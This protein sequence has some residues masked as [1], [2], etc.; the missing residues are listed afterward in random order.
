M[1]ITEHFDSDE[2]SCHDGTDYPKEWI[3]SKLKPLCGDLE[4]IRALTNQQMNIES[5]Y[6]TVSWNNAIYKARG[7]TPTDSE[8]CKGI[9]ADIILSG[10]SS[11]E[12]YNAISVLIKEK[13]IPDGGLGLYRWGC[14]YDLRCTLDNK[15]PARWVKE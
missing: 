3:D 9:A 10:M 8:H 4:C 14:H 6:R 11:H 2:F 13:A 5:G 12:L 7:E 1:Q 15:P